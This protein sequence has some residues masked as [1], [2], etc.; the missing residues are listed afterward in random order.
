MTVIKFNTNSKIVI[1]NQN[2][3]E[4]ISS[5][6]VNKRLNFEGGSKDFFYPLQDALL[7]IKKYPKFSK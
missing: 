7:Q 3:P 2:G 4:K 6:E 1:G 5:I